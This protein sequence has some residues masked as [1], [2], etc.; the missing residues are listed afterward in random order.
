MFKTNLKK[1]IIKYLLKIMEP[2]EQHPKR[3]SIKNI[4]KQRNLEK[5]NE[6][7]KIKRYND[8]EF[9]NRLINIQKKGNIRINDLNDLLMHNNLNSNFLEYYFDILNKTDKNRFK[10]EI[11]L[12]YPFMTPKLCNK[13]SIKKEISEKEK[14]FHL[15]KNIINANENQISEIISEEYKFPEELEKLNYDKEEKKI[16]YRW[17][18]YGTK[19]IDFSVV[20]NEEYFYYVISNYILKTLKEN[21]FFKFSKK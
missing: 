2:N 17:G 10:N 15:F 3:I 8:E 18:L 7:K 16:I 14:F 4:Y 20:Y 21:I 12:Y 13:F 11:I 19:I 5:G 1:Y 9:N 6:N